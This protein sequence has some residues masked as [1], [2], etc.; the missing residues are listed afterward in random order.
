MLIT[1]RKPLVRPLFAAILVAVLQTA[2]LGYMIE[3]RASIL[4]NGTDVLLK[5]VP[6]DPRDLL[7]GDYVILAYDISSIP[8]DKVTGGY[9]TEATDARMSVRLEKQPDGFWIVSEAAF[10]DLAPKTGTI[11]ANTQPF[12]YYPTP[13]APNAAIGVDYGIERY[14][15]PEGEGL[16]LEEARNASAL[17]VTARVDEEGRMQIRLIAVDGKPLYEEPLY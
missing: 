4:R 6:I 15:V 2:F 1:T 10:A 8:A 3:S 12:Y 5:T 17:S 14:Y 11:V 16:V 9:P 7:R 13:D